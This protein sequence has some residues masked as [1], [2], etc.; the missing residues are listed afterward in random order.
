M[1]ES[2]KDMLQK[3]YTVTTWLPKLLR[4][5]EVFRRVEDGA[6]FRV[7]SDSADIKTPARSSFQIAQCKAE[8][9][10]LT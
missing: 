7:T 4:F 6:V 10:E 2:E 8:R 3:S 1:S 9:W 5:G